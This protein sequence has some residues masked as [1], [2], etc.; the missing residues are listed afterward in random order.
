MAE[1]EKGDRMRR[2]G[3]GRRS[4]RQSTDSRSSNSNSSSPFKCVR[5]PVVDWQEPRSTAP[6]TRGEGSKVSRG[7]EAH[8]SNQSNPQLEK[9]LR[10]IHADKSDVDA[11]EHLAIR[12]RQ[13][14]A[15][16]HQLVLLLLESFSL[17]LFPHRIIQPRPLRC[18]PRVRKKHQVRDRLVHRPQGS[19]QQIRLKRNLRLVDFRG[20]WRARGCRPGGGRRPR[21]RM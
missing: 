1:M 12:P 2:L 9:L 21:M 13:N 19:K 17:P 10:L 7:A 11:I 6:V 16:L 5:L 4:V 8:K 18:S 15:N 14:I 3:V 20:G